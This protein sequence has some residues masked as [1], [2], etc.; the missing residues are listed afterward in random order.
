MSDTTIV[1]LVSDSRILFSVNRLPVQRAESI[2]EPADELLHYLE[3]ALGQPVPQMDATYPVALNLY[4]DL[5]AGLA[6]E[7][8]L[9]EITAESVTLR[10]GTVQA[11]FHAVYHFLET[12]V[13]VRWLWP[14]ADGE[15]V[16][17]RDHQAMPLGTIREA[18][19]YQ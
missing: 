6:R 15:V 8:F 2:L 3:L 17:R 14:G 5:D 18:P 9:I 13:G 10:A 12:V 4:Y 11:M 7:E 16:P 1:Q 19:D